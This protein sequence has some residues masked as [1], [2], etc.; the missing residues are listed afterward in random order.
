MIL[1]K[2]NS[3][4]RRAALIVGLAAASPVMSG[5]TQ[6]DVDWILAVGEE[7]GR[8]NGVIDE[9][10]NINWGE[11]VMQVFGLPSGDPL[12]DAA[13]DAGMV[14]ANLES[15]EA[16]ARE[17]AQ[18]GD[19]AKVEAAIESRT[20]DWGF[21]EQKAALL[22]AMNDFPGAEG[23]FADSEA[24]V[25]S[26]VFQ[27]GNCP[28]LARNMFTHRIDALQTQLGLRPN[29]QLQAKADETQAQLDALAAGQPIAF[30]P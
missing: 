27:G 9:A 16:A 10:G 7:W 21:H 2:L 13:L 17:G 1:S 30:C 26:Q 22:M 8:A 11:A 14:V 3:R 12:V 5:C 19:L 20:K 18:N 15:A 29:D 24:L 6:A 23:S 28:N 25:R 4:V